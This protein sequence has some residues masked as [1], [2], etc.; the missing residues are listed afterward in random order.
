MGR[1]LRK[2]L[3]MVTIIQK[4]NKNKKKHADEDFEKN[5]FPHQRAFLYISILFVYQLRIISQQNFNPFGAKILMIMNTIIGNAKG[6]ISLK[7]ISIKLLNAS[8][9]GCTNTV[10]FINL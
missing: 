8:L 1:L 3:L 7:K 2:E 9:N 5:R 6:V 10:K 4:V